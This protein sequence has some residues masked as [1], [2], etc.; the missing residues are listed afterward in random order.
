MLNVISVQPLADGWAVTH[1]QIAVP[2]V[3]LS[4]A[5]AEAAALSMGSRLAREGQTT[6]IVIYL[7]DGVLGGRFICRAEGANAAGS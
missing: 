2:Q 7:R 6:E 5:K 1:P 4:G 3:F